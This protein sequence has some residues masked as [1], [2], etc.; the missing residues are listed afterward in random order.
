VGANR[1]S[2]MASTCA[3]AGY[4]AD[5]K[6][7]VSLLGLNAIRIE[8][9]FLGQATLDRLLSLRGVHESSQWW[10]EL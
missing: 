4:P 9:D 1:N 2:L 8:N 10:R 6:P 3:N 5:L 7:V